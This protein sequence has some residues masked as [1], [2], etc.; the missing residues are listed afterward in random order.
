[1]NRAALLS[2]L[3]KQGVLFVGKNPEMNLST[4]PWRMRDKFIRIRG[5]GYWFKDTPYPPIGHEPLKPAPGEPSA[6]LFPNSED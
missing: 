3:A 6:G 1:M 2:E 4:I 5:H